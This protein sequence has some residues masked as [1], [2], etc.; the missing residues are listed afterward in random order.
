MLEMCS[1]QLPVVLIDDDETCCAM[2]SLTLQNV[3]VKNVHCISDSRQVLPFLQKHGAALLL[4]DLVMPHMSGYELLKVISY[5]YPGIQ[6]VVIS[7]ANELSAAVDCMK[8][9]TLDYLSKPVEPNRLIAC[10]NNALTINAMQGELQSLKKRLLGNSLDCPLSFEAIKTRSN[11]MLAL[12]QYTEVIARSSQPI[13]I[14]GETGVGKELMALAVHRLSGVGG[15]FV[16]VNVAG[17]DD[18]TFS[19][20]LF[21]HKKGAYTGADQAREGLIA[22]AAGGTIILDEIGDLEERSQIKL[23]RLLQEGEYYPVGS[24]TLKKSMARIVAVTNQN[25]PDLVADKRFRRDLYYRL[26]SHEI[27]IPP[28]RDRPEDIP[29]LLEHFIREAALSYIRNPPPVSVRALTHLL[30]WSFPGN[31]RELKGMVYDAVAR[32]TEG[33]LTALSFGAHKGE[34]TADQYVISSDSSPEYTIDAL[35]GHFPTFHEIEEYLLKEAVR[36]SGGNINIAAAMLG[37]TRQTISNR[38]KPRK[39]RS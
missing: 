31:V 39:E 38:S 6:T 10:V 26:C 23:L 36:R 32:H 35:F 34:I 28:L 4:L 1:S 16:S 30:G 33:E 37:I 2:M 7:G 25:L 22:R 19:D 29:L 12:F 17:L 13:L 5:D 3:G 11:R 18:S 21:G 27:Q 15:E 24:D 9:G 8:L 14:T 20:A